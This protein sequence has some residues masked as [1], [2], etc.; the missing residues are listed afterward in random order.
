[1]AVATL[2]R[3]A[4][5]SDLRKAGGCLSVTIDGHTLALFA[6]GEKIFAVDNR[7]P[8]M[9]FPLHR[10]S[11]QDG[12]LTCHWHYARFD[13]ASG[14]TFDQWADDVPTFPV[15]VRGDDILVDL[16]ARRDPLAHQRQR[17]TDGLE[18]NI[19]LVIAKAM[20]TLFDNGADPKEAFER[21]VLFGTQYRAAGWGPGLT[22]LTCMMNLL[23]HLRQSDRARALFHGLSAV[24]NDCEGQPAR[25]QVGPLPGAAPAPDRL[26]QWFRQFIEVRDA[27][28]AERC[29]SSAIH[30]GMQPAPIADMLL[31]AATDHRYIDNGH[32]V[33]FTNKAFEA[34]DILGWEQAETILTS[35]V[36]SYANAER[37]EESSAWRHPID[38]IGILTRTFEQMPDALNEGLKHQKKW[39]AESTLITTLLGDDPQA[40]TDGLL[41]GLRMSGNPVAVASA[42]SY[43]AALRIARFHT[44]NEFGD[45]DTA[46]HTFSFAC[47]VQR[48][49]QRIGPF[50]ADNDLPV[51]GIFDAAMSIYLDRFLNVPPA[52]VPQSNGR[53]SNAVQS[54]ANLADLLDRQQ[55]VDEAG[56][57]TAQYLYGGGASPALVAM[58]GSLLLREDRNFHTIQMIE[59]A[60]RQF[61]EQ[62]DPSIGANLLVAA[63]RYLAAHAPTMRAQGQ[64]FQIAYRLAR[65]ERLFE[66]V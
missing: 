47:A 52:R 19:P 59:A 34:L 58:L 37:M 7:C 17:L 27:E 32:V 38:L 46:L 31:S 42:V 10:G 33:D 6:Y 3:A 5:L 55:Q 13:L 18:R 51:R 4:A 28:G 44:S 16:T 1:M 29:I 63:A 9:G 2:V 22:I 40:I 23:P 36:G 56:E 30:A 57:R 8:H 24:A 65:G 43:A 61:T 20:N 64:T 50:G 12:I 39:S 45:W 62:G 21:G 41:D 26:K 49:L 15:E 35:L 60:V 48:G 25:F 11:V 53:L 66:D 54:L 14:G